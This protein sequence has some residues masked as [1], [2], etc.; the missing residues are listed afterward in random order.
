MNASK[1]KVKGEAVS[2]FNEIDQLDF[3]R[4]SFVRGKEKSRSKAIGKERSRVASFRSKKQ[5]FIK[6]D[7]SRRFSC[8][9]LMSR[10]SENLV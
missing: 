10:R 8:A 6:A 3:S 4:K 9:R 5:K 2:E 1:L 7:V